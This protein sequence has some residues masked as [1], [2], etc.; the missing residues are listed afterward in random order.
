M[1]RLYEYPVHICL[2]G[3]IFL[4]ELVSRSWFIQNFYLG[5]SSL[6]YAFL[7]Y[8]YLSI[9]LSLIS[10][11]INSLPINH[12]ISWSIYRSKLELAWWLRYVTVLPWPKVSV[13]TQGKSGNWLFS[14]QTYPNSTSYDLYLCKVYHPWNRKCPL[15]TAI[16]FLEKEI[17]YSRWHFKVSSNPWLHHNINLKRK[18]MILIFIALLTALHELF[19]RH[20]MVSS[21][22]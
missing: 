3:S 16:N 5:N 2:P 20:L 22:P 17:K 7:I 1:K 21:S 8:S 12:S 4:I 13:W 19:Y 15:E 9:S 18:W 11:H 14:H 10:A 6:I